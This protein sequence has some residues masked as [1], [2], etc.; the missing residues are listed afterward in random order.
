M[1]GISQNWSE[2]SYYIL[3]IS[4]VDHLAPNCFFSQNV[5]SHL[6]ENQKNLTSLFKN[7][8]GHLPAIMFSPALDI[9]HPNDVYNFTKFWKKKAQSTFDH[10]SFMPDG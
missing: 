2:V 10:Q 3:I 7:W 9:K 6:D 1:Y 4:H 5:T 8:A